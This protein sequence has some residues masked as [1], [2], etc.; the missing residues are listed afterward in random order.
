MATISKAGVVDGLVVYDV[1]VYRIVDA[2]DGT[3]SNN[4]I[5]NA[6]LKQGSLSNTTNLA[7]SHAEGEG[8][9]ATGDFSH[10]EGKD[11]AAS[12]DFS[13]A[14]GKNSAASGDYSHAEGEQTAAQGSGSHAE[15]ERTTATGNF[16][17]A[18]GLYTI[19]YNDHQTVFGRYNT[20]NN[21]TDYFVIGDGPNAGNRSDAFG[22]N[23]TRTYISNS[24]LLPDIITSS[25]ENIV[26]TFNTSSK[27]VYY[28]ASSALFAPGSGLPGA[29]EQSIQFNSA[30]VFRGDDS[31]KFIY[32]LEAFQHGTASVAVG[33]G[34]HAI[35]SGSIASGSYQ[36]VVGQFNKQNNTTDLFIV[37]SGSS[38]NR[39]D[40]FGVSVTGT[41]IS[42]SFY[43]PS[44]SNTAQTFVLT[45]DTASKQVYY[46]TGSVFANSA[47][48]SPGG[49][50][51]S[52]QFNK[53]NAFSGSARFIFDYNINKTLLTGSMIIS[54]S[55]ND[56]LK[57]I[58]SGSSSPLVGTY[59]SQGNLLTVTDSLSGSIFSVNNISGL[60]MFEV[61]SDKTVLLGDPS[62]PA[63]HSSTA[64][65][66]AATSFTLG[67]VPTSSYDGMFYE[68]VVKSGSNARSGYINSVWAGT[69]I[70]SSSLTTS[71]IGS[72]SGVILY[73]TLS[74]SYVVLTGSAT[75]ANWEIKSIVRAI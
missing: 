38:T 24:L 40:A 6:D 37:G 21:S 55:G 7:N 19:A 25:N 66:P 26:L 10:A 29:P 30:S 59:G 44:L 17:H 15:G 74:G 3:A 34:S 4:I 63:Y 56:Q 47:A 2:L 67:L 1:H 16:S 31:L 9:D 65:I 36:T 60:T 64:L 61:F 58:G 73:T 49:P 71:D 5:I 53:S 18:G 46:L 68:Y 75:T 70:R 42:N 22:V 14:E 57:I 51:K 8:T 72:T 28:T 43:L 54:S 11:S 12:G 20:V 27:T 23:A 69:T 50:D 48:T 35:G 41:Y 33:T 32:T 52:I 13:H 39:A 62:T 45:Y